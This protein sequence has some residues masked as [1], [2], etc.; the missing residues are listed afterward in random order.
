[1]T[2]ISRFCLPDRCDPVE[3]LFSSASNSNRREVIGV[4]GSAQA[5]RHHIRQGEPKAPRQGVDGNVVV[6]MNSPHHSLVWTMLP[7]GPIGVHA[8]R[9]F[10]GGFKDRAGQ[11][12]VLQRERRRQAGDA[13]ADIPFGYCLNG[14]IAGA[15]ERKSAQALVAEFFNQI[16]AR[17]QRF[18]A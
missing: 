1:M 16:A 10:V 18:A 2:Q 6:S 12:L 3:I 7:V 15:V 9:R 17:E 13:G 4:L 5:G 11:S 8:G 14:S